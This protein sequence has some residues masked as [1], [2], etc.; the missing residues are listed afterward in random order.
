M[1]Y[2]RKCPVC[3]IRLL[4]EAVEDDGNVFA[5][6]SMDC[7]E[8]QAFL[9]IEWKPSV[10]EIEMDDED[11]Y[12]CNKGTNDILSDEQLMKELEALH[13]PDTGSSQRPEPP[14]ASKMSAIAVMAPQPSTRIGNSS[15]RPNLTSSPRK[16]AGH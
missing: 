4:I 6:D 7:P 9:A 1:Q 13:G 11:E 15:P 8:C 2:K 5:Q 16:P 12:G 14:T 10:S 3:G